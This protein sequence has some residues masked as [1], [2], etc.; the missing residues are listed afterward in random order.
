MTRRFLKD[1]SGLAAIEYALLGLPF[2]ALLLATFDLAFYFFRDHVLQAS[3]AAGARSVRTGQVGRAADQAGVFRTAVCNAAAPAFACNELVFDV[4]R[5]NSFS[6]IATLPTITFDANGAPN[7]AVF[8]PGAPGQVQSIR[9]VAQHRFV[10]P[11]LANVVQ[12]ARGQVFLTATVII[13]G[14]PWPVN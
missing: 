14:E 12:G 2:L 1:R 4:R 8:Q 11:F 13:R 3:A 6:E 9:I 10:T 7:N 5:W